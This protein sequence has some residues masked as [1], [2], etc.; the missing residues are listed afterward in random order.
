MDISSNTLEQMQ[1]AVGGYVQAVDIAPDITLWCNEEG[2]MM[3]L[4]HN[5]FAQL[6]W[7]RAFGAG[8]DYIVGTVVITGGVDDEGETT[9]LSLEQVASLSL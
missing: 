9:G 7:D 3:S 8:T 6:L 5:L 4:E 2:K 1:A